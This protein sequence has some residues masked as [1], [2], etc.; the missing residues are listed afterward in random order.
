MFFFSKYALGEDEPRRFD[1]DYDIAVSWQRLIEGKNIQE[2]D[3]VLLNHEL[4]ES[5]LMNTQGLSYRDAHEMAT[6]LY[7]YQ[8]FI[9]ELDRKAGLK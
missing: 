2:M 1:P 4:M 3:R 9:N 6:E 7:N 5:R 8:A